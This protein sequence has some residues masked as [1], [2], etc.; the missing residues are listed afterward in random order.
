MPFIAI[1]EKAF[2][3][4][5]NEQYE[6]LQRGIAVQRRL[7]QLVL[8]ERGL[9]EVARALAAAIGG[10]VADARR[11]RR[12]AGAPRA[13]GAAIAGARWRRSAAEVAQRTGA[14]RAAAV[15]ARARAR[16]AG[17]RSRCRW[18]PDA[19]GGPQAWLVAVRDA[20]GLGEFERLIL[21][22]AVTVVALEL[23]RRRVVRD[24]ERRLAGDVLAEAA[25]R[26]TSTTDELR[27]GCAPSASATTAAVLVF[28][29]DDPAG[30]G[31]AARAG[32]ARRGRRCLVA[33]ARRD[34]CARSIDADEQRP[35]RARL[36]RARDALASGTARCA[37]P[38]AAPRPSARCAAAST[39]RAT[40]SRRRRSPN[41]DAPEVASWRDLGAFQLL[42]SVQDDEA[43]RSTATAC[44]ARSRTARATTAA[45]CCARWRRS[46]STTASGSA[47]PATS[48]ATAT[49]C[50][51]GSAAS[52]S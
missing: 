14:R 48:T 43:L 32:P 16:R 33:L 12:D 50:A 46:S 40:R 25:R 3:Q 47:P 7:E 9:D 19:A 26:A 38:P 42:L 49:R 24:T 41:G 45:S 51:T 29:L 31:G 2:A 11:Q 44:S 13:S 5:V 34:C 10:A 52:R 36:R 21:Q 22:Q 28:A 20:G 17:A 1:T 15:R 4:L 6:I 39:R 35:A 27:L 23:M 30:G 8:E 18:P 37:P